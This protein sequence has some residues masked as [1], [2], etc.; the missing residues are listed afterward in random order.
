MPLAHLANG[1]DDWD[2][3]MLWIISS[4]E[5]VHVIGDGND[6]NGKSKQSKGKG[7]K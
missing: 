2:L 4:L 1:F 7:R 3:Y 6:I 5:D